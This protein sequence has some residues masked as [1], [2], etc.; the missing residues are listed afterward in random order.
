MSIVVRS[1]NFCP[2]DRQL[3][4]SVFL[5]T[6]PSFQKGGMVVLL[7][8]SFGVHGFPMVFL[9]LLFSTLLALEEF[10]LQRCKEQSKL[11]I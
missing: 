11:E 5:I 3:R 4:I 2:I 6:L 8:T 9:P 7:C 10:T 1:I